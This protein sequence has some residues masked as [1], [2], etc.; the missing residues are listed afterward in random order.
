MKENEKKKKLT[1]KQQA[2]L[3]AKQ[4]KEA[5]QT[6][7]A[8]SLI[9]HIFTRLEQAKFE[10]LMEELEFE[11]ED[12]TELDALLS[13]AGEVEVEDFIRE[14]LLPRY[15]SVG[16]LKVAE[17]GWAI[18]RTK[19]SCQH[20]LRDLKRYYR[21]DQ[22]G[23]WYCSKSCHESYMDFARNIVLDE[24]HPYDWD[25]QDS[26]D[27][28]GTFERS[29]DRLKLDFA[30]RVMKYINN[31]TTTE[32]LENLG[33]ICEKAR[34]IRSEIDYSFL[35]FQG[36]FQSEG[37]D[38][39]FAWEIY[40]NTKDMLSVDEQIAKWC[41][42]QVTSIWEGHFE[43]IM[44]TIYDQEQAYVKRY[45]SPYDPLSST[46]TIAK[47]KLLDPTKTFGYELD[48]MYGVG[49]TRPDA[50]EPRNRLH[51]QLDQLHQ[52]IQGWK[53]ST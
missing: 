44:S 8:D 33:A 36:Y 25:Y 17:N 16:W 52:R 22:Y 42:E 38:G 53:P 45:S 49:V 29:F 26:L 50:L 21:L 35:Q 41:L 46:Q 18:Q 39:V 7:E 24:D 32:I 51:S 2:E 13:L 30:K 15:V 23:N 31:D 28:R 19:T 6:V 40:Q 34:D 11:Y 3:D 1:K 43:R 37:D 4:A 27:L 10:V 20:C 47:Y 5:K 12:S 14:T 48:D 9:R